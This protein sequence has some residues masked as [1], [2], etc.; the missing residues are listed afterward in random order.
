MRTVS[1]QEHL[2]RLEVGQAA[3]D[4]QAQDVEGNRVTLRSLSGDGKTLLVFYRGEWC[5][6]SKKELAGLARDYARFK[7]VNSQIVAVSSSEPKKSKELV[8]NLSLPFVLLSDPNLEEI[9]L[10]GVRVER[11]EI[12]ED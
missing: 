11:G 9:D 3:P 4:F 2:V 7:E 1:T 8:R 10:Y 5:P 6:V 12:R